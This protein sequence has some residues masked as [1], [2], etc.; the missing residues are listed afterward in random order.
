MKSVLISICPKRR[1]R[2]CLLKRCK[3]E[4]EAN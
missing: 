3:I 2:I 4:E 1:S